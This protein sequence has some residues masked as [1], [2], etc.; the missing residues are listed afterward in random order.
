[1]AVQGTATYA[2]EPSNAHGVTGAV[3]TVLAIYA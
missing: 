2:V 3:T 1:V